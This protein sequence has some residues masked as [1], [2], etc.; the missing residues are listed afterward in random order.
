MDR[1]EAIKRIMGGYD[2]VWMK[3]LQ[4]KR[5]AKTGHGSTGPP[6][7]PQSEEAGEECEREPEGGADD[8]MDEETKAQLLE[9]LSQ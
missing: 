7:G 8:E 5:A 9:L 1:D 3:G 6:E 2:D 4:A